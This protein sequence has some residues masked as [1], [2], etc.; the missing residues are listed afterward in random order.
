MKRFKDDAKEV[1]MGF[2]CGLML[3]NYNEIFEG[4]QLEVF[5]IVQVAR[6]L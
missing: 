4:D 2:E 6:S 1:R 5:E 3:K